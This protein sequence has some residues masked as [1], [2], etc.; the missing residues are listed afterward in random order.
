MVRMTSMLGVAL[1][2]SG[3][4]ARRIAEWKPVEA[5]G[6]MALKSY[7]YMSRSRSMFANDARKERKVK[8]RAKQ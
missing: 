8:L 5:S 6:G 3:A 7:S 4:A 1:G 2:G